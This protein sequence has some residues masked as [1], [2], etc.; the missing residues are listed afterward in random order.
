M[1]TKCSVETAAA[2]DS[3]IAPYVTL[4]Q[5]GIRLVRTDH[6]GEFERK[7]QRKLD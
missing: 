6:G 1:K 4:E 3:C 7:L 5:L 2:L